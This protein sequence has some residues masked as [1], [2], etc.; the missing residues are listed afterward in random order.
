[1]M[2]LALSGVFLLGFVAG[3]ATLYS[4]ARETKE[5]DARAI[6]RAQNQDVL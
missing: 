4:L 5:Q 3:V 1:M 6:L 2:A